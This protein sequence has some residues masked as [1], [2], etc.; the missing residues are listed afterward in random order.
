MAWP[1][2]AP[3]G[4]GMEAKEGE[5]HASGFESPTPTQGLARLGD[6]WQGGAP[7]GVA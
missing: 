6:A 7:L 1:G 3:L 5:R 4:I 2:G